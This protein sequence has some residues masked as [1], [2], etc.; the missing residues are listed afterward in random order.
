MTLFFSVIECTFVGCLSY[1]GTGFMEI[2]ISQRNTISKYA[3]SWIMC[4]Y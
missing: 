4:I 2:L 3:P 1:T